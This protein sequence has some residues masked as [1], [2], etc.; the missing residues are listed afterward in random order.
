LAEKVKE[1]LATLAHG[2]KAREKKCP[3][4]KLFGARI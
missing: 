4:P 3:N 2:Y 1:K